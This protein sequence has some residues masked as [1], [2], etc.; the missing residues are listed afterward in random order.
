M[1]NNIK[2]N[3]IKGGGK[4]HTP[5]MSHSHSEVSFLQRLG[6]NEI[7]LNVVSTTDVLTDLLSN[8]VSVLLNVEL[9]IGKDGHPVFI[10]RD[11]LFETPNPEG[12]DQLVAMWRINQENAIKAGLLAYQFALNNNMNAN[13][14]AAILPVGNTMISAEIIVLNNI[15]DST[16][17]GL[18]SEC[19]EI[20]TMCKDVVLQSNAE[21]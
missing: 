12:R 9:L 21:Q 18:T 20:L 16:V 7:K 15:V 3:D 17:K 4:I 5:E 19:A 10:L 14:A 13:K 11:A 2:H 6:N 8:V 1:L